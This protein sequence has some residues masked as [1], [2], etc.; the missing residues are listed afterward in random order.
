LARNDGRS[1]NQGDRAEGLRQREA[2]DLADKKAGTGR[3]ATNAA[4][5]AKNREQVR[6]RGDQDIVQA[7]ETA[8]SGS[9]GQAPASRHKA[10][11]GRDFVRT[12]AQA[13]AAGARGAPNVS[14][15]LA[16]RGRSDAQQEAKRKERG[17]APLNRGRA[18]GGLRAKPYQ[19]RSL[20]ERSKARDELR[21]TSPRRMGGGVQ[22]DFA[23][24]SQRALSTVA[25]R[26]K[27]GVAR[28]L[29]KRGDR[30]GA[31]TRPF[32]PQTA[33]AAPTR[34]RPSAASG[35]PSAPAKPRGKLAPKSPGA[36]ARSKK[37]RGREDKLRAM[38][39]KTTNAKDRFKLTQR[40]VKMKN[41]R[42]ALRGKGKAGS[43]K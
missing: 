1:F 27:A 34:P 33:S 28:R 9:T 18:P 30:P 40:I 3:W 6:G 20:A 8:G 4:Q 36:I 29:D 24:N 37:I 10:L 5:Q 16:S 23:N 38:R 35:R 32:R 14:R 15:T 2:K 13:T 21:A 39:S 41:R 19:A 7:R 12:G 26:S 17:V 43:G 11:L 42:R 25:E 31:S 22:P